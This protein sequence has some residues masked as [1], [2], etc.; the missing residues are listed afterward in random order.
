M[1]R[2]NTETTL[3]FPYSTSVLLN[4]LKHENKVMLDQWTKMLATIA[5]TDVRICA[6]IGRR[7]GKEARNAAAKTAVAQASV[8]LSRNLEALPINFTLKTT[9]WVWI[10]A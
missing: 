4:E 1:L 7:E 2:C 10:T 9:S 3:Q 8:P 5:G 6:V